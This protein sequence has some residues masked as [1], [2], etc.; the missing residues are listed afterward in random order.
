MSEVEVDLSKFGKPEPEPSEAVRKK[1]QKLLLSGAVYES[2]IPGVFK[3]RASNGEDAYTVN[4][5]SG[6]DE[7]YIV[8]CTCLSGQNKGPRVRCS[9][10]LAV[11]TYIAR[12][13]D[14]K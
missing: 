1:A 5:S 3:V 14:S 8:T 2:V 9:H 4:V 12:Q 11:R 7:S 13:E 6:G 10:S